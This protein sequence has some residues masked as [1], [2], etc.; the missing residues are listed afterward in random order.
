MKLRK[1]GV[2]K[3]AVNI[4]GKLMKADGTEVKVGDELTDSRG[5]IWILR[6]A[7]G[8]SGGGGDAKVYVDPYII[9]DEDTRTI[10]RE[11]YARIFGL[12]WME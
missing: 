3:M 8:P 9:G 12:R 5:Q 7:R 10:G 6:S 1:R 4:D 2:W 11:F